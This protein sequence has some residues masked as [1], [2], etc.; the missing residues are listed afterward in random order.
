[1]A[2]Y[3]K[4]PV[5]IEAVQW[6]GTVSAAKATIDWI[7]A[8]GGTASYHDHPSALSI[9]TLEGTMTAMPGD[10]IIKGVQGEFYPCKPDIFAATYEPVADAPSDED[11][12]RDAMTEAQAHPG[13]TITR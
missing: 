10:W 9:N 8:H 5:V 11:R 6:D 7:L 12:I 2:L 4:K 3:R 1:M 13:R